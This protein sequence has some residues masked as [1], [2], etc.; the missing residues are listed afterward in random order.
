M[1]LEFFANDRYSIL[2]IL[3]ENQIKIKDDEYVSLSQQEIA[4]LAKF[5][6]QKAN[7]II[8]ELI[9]QGY[10]EIFN[11]MRGKYRVTSKG[12]NAINIINKSTLQEE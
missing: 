10:V 6:K 11:N 8:N 9:D 7:K 3:K 2:I 1:S 5:S 12:K 4:D